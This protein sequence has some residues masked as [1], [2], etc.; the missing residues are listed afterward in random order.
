LG[1][2]FAYL[3]TAEL[4][5]YELSL[6]R[7]S[8][9]EYK[10]LEEALAEWQLRYNRHPDLG[11][12]TGDLLRIKVREFWDKLPY[13]ARKEPPKF[14]DGWLAGFKRRYGLKERR[15]H[16]EGASA[17]IDEESEQMMEEIRVVA[18]EYGPD[19]TYNIDESAYY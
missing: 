3:D 14:S 5:K 6:S 11:L 15:R 19:L 1:P 10:E 8:T 7:G 12:T 16:G 18:R 13:Y 2:K 9:A 4:S 17:Q